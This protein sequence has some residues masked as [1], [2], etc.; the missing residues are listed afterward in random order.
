MGGVRSKKPNSVAKL[1]QKFDMTDEK[2]ICI[3]QAP[4][5]IYGSLRL[6]CTCRYQAVCFNIGELTLD[7]VKNL[8]VRFLH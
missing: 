3:F 2:N 1:K 6:H 8:I 7:S 4:V 5:V